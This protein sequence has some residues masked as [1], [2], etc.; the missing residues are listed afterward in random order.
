MICRCSWPEESSYSQLEVH[1]L[2]GLVEWNSSHHSWHLMEVESTHRHVCSD[3]SDIEQ[4]QTPFYETI[5][6]VTLR[7]ESNMKEI[8]Q[9]EFNSFNFILYTFNSLINLILLVVVLLHRP[10]HQHV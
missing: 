9:T 8:H 5:Q 4:D 10:A 3:G 6:A 7:L 1:I 2:H